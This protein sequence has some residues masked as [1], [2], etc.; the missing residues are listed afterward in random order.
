[1]FAF[2][3]LSEL[4]TSQA[5]PSCTPTAISAHSICIKAYKRGCCTLPY[6]GHCLKAQ[7]YT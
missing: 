2:V 7:N 4:A 6:L 1:M 3:R 5:N